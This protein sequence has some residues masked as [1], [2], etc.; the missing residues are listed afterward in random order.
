MGEF[1]KDVEDA[2]G[3]IGAAKDAVEGDSFNTRHFI[4]GD[5]DDVKN[6]Y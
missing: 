2:D 5:D 3:V 6:V 1:L 4:C